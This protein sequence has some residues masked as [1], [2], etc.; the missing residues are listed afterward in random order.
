MG[1]LKLHRFEQAYSN[2]ILLYIRRFSKF[3]LALPDSFIDNIEELEKAI[4]LFDELMH[5]L[6]QNPT[7]NDAK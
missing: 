4:K 1:D 6:N 5:T 3:N 7:V 2:F